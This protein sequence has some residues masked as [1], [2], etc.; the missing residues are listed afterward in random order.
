LVKV[1]VLMNPLQ[2]LVKY[3]Q[4]SR[5]V[6]TVNQS[7]QIQIGRE[8]CIVQGITEID[9]ITFKTTYTPKPEMYIARII[10]IASDV[11][12]NIKSSSKRTPDVIYSDGVTF[13]TKIGS[14]VSYVSTTRGEPVIFSIAG[15]GAVIDLIP[16]YPQQT[17]TLYEL[18]TITG[19]GTTIHSPSRESIELHR[20]IYRLV[21][22][23]PAFSS[24][25]Q[26][27]LMAS[28]SLV[29]SSSSFVQ[30]H[31]LRMQRD[32]LTNELSVFIDNDPVLAF[33]SHNKYMVHVYTGTNIYRLGIFLD[34]SSGKLECYSLRDTTHIDAVANSELMT[35]D[36]LTKLYG[37]L[38][39]TL[40]IETLLLIQFPR[41]D[42]PLFEWQL[43]P[44]RATSVV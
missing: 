25:P 42:S 14:L 36:Q 38:C 22:M 5:R 11:R 10:I 1:A 21:E 17:M 19:E 8:L 32:A 2:D 16:L 33:F 20:E 23:T 26:M 3:T 41:N 24:S 4:R 40:P 44:I 29:H 15:A 6:V 12:L 13:A 39:P 37:S 31:R 30:N 35:L 27:T 28:A 18:T 9:K 34:R 7:I 43:V